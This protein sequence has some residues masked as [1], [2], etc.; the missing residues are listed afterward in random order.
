MTDVSSVFLESPLVVDD[1]R[2]A[3]KIK[4]PNLND[5]ASSQLVVYSN[6]AAFGNQQNWFDS[7]FI[8]SGTIGNEDDVIVVVVPSATSRA[9]NFGDEAS[10]ASITSKMSN[11]D[12]T[13]E[14]ER[15]IGV[16]SDEMKKITNNEK[17]WKR[18]FWFTQIQCWHASERF[19]W[20]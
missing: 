2:D 18:R 12:S 19:L 17:K 7:R 13:Y 10:K 15:N 16:S 6:M 8:L 5:V 4:L 1:F 9:L 20:R 14:Y 11:D 3:V